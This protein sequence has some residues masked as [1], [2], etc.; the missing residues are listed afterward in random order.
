MRMRATCAKY[1]G[2]VLVG[3]TLC[4]A[5][6]AVNSATDC[7]LQP[8]QKARI[9]TIFEQMI[10]RGHAPG[11]VVDIRCN[12]KPWLESALGMSSIAHNRA[13]QT[14][15]L[16]RIYSMTKPITSLLILLLA[17][18]GLLSID[19]P[20]ANHLPE[21]AS[22]TV[23]DGTT[24]LPPS[25]VA[26][27]RAITIRDLLRHSAGITYINGGATPVHQLYLAKG[28]DNGS[29]ADI[30][31]TDGSDRIDSLGELSKRI[32][33]VPLLSQPGERFSYGNSHDV[34]GHLAAVVSKKSFREVLAE[35][36]L[37]PLGM[38]DSGFQVE[39]ERFER[40]TAAYHAPTR[41][42]NPGRILR[43]PNPTT[44]ER[45]SLTMIDDPFKSVYSRR[46]PADFGGAGLVTTASD[47]QQFLQL[48]LHNGS[49]NNNTVVRHGLVAQ[50][51]INQ[52]NSISIDKSNLSQQ[53]LGY[54]FGLAIVLDSSLAPGKLPEGSYFWGGA[55]STN[56]WVDPSRG[57]TGVFMTQVFG[58]DVNA[59]FAA[60]LREIYAPDVAATSSKQ[61]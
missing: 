18:D 35:R 53:G 33:S 49:L 2:V 14:N 40:L 8:E 56:F 34:L 50:M 10:D 39:K 23:W 27:A 43:D 58:G 59:F 52:L 11:S 20:V 26:A 22:A 9:V 6:S 37:K 45:G 38:I 4:A 29:G 13:M 3:S 36:V 19:D 25:S 54:G 55:A 48:M 61:Q 44:L 57:I 46:R 15:D 5:T 30:K 24:A 16:F 42:P 41:A 51:R 31:P 47:Y 28:I 7:G 60:A 21:F 32:A 12:G 17:Q 1:L